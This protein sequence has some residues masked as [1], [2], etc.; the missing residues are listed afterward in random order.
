VSYH[1]DTPGE[2]VRAVRTDETRR[3]GS[4]LRVFQLLAAAGGA[5]LFALGLFAV[6]E[7]DF[8]DGWARTTGEVAG[9]GFGAI[10]AIA[11]IVLG[12]AILVA[13]LA[14]QDRAGAALA[15]LITL[16][17]GIAGFVVQDNADADLQVDGGTAALF[18]AI[19][20]AVFV[21]SLVPWWSRRRTTTY[22]ER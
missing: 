10:T 13:T 16:V 19:G 21:L 12:G 22:V 18:V 7:V 11:A 2:P 5:V 6:F 17:V 15:G 3:S 1:V 20:A 9:L 8:G 14:D 4:G